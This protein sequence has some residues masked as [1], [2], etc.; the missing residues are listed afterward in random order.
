M[1][2][3]LP[4]PAAGVALAKE[5]IQPQSQYNAEK[6]ISSFFDVGQCRRQTTRIRFILSFIFD[7]LF[8]IIF[9]SRFLQFSS[10]NSQF[11][12]SR[13]VTCNISFHLNFHFL[14]GNTCSMPFPF[15]YSTNQ[16]TNRPTSCLSFARSFVLQ[17]FF[18]MTIMLRSKR[19]KKMKC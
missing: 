7:N 17:N 6:Y 1:F 2:P 8:M 9:C 15:F 10:L 11:Q 16:T 5:L 3:S 18:T 14:S 12:H 13:V 19:E 4:S